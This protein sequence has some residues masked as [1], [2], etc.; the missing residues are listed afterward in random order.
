[1]TSLSNPS[2]IVGAIG[3]LCVM[4]VQREGMAFV[5]LCLLVI[6]IYCVFPIRRVGELLMSKA[7]GMQ[8]QAGGLSNP[9]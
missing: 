4:A 2:L 3:A 1:M 8:Q 6:P 9:E 7:L 5:L